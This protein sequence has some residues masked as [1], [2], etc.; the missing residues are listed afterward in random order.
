MRG[1]MYDFIEMFAPHLTG[2]LVNE[3]IKCRSALELE[4]LFAEVTIPQA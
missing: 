3:A 4:S 1:Y 2:V